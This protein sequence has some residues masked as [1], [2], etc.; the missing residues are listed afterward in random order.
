MKELGII[1]A[2][3]SLRTPF[4]DGFMKIVTVLG[5]EMLFTVVVA[6]V[7]WCFNKRFGYKLINVYLIGCSIIEGMKVLV[8]RARPY[9]YDGVTSV[10]EKTGGY[11]FP[12][13]H[14][15]SIANLST[16]ISQKVKKTS[17]TI[18]LFAME[19]RTTSKS[20]TILKQ[21]R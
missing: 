18:S 19:H 10:G 6:V 14:S 8:G 17:V 1:K 2:I 21:R 7:F 9:T 4:F 3:Q 15:H 20:S 5:D 11:S 13:G 12:S 16:Q